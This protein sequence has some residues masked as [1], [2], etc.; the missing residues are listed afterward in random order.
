MVEVGELLIKM[1]N[2]FV[3]KLVVNAIVI[4]VGELLIEMVNSFAVKLVVM[5]VEE[6]LIKTMNSSV[7][8]N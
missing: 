8:E 4:E 3:V 2:S 5:K 6:I 1:V 7:V